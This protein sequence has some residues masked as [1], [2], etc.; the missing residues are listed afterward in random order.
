MTPE[1]VASRARLATETA[2]AASL[3]AAT[4]EASVASE[5]AE[6]RARRDVSSKCGEK[7][8]RV[9]FDAPRT[10]Q[11][12]MARA[13]L[14]RE[15]AASE[16]KARETQRMRAAGLRPLSSSVDGCERFSD[17][18]LGVDPTAHKAW[19]S[20]E[21]RWSRFEKDNEA[22]D[23]DGVCVYMLT[24][25]DIPFPSSGGALLKALAAWGE[26]SEQLFDDG[27]S[28]ARARRVAAMRWHPDK[29]TQR[30]GKRLDGMSNA[31]RES[32]ERQ[33]VETYQDIQRT[34]NDL[35]K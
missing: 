19:R 5:R 12:A 25:N 11:E 24:I 26:E 3:E 21:S 22:M 16:R 6:L 27:A 1:E 33:V 35:S 29:F 18:R 31:D 30:F 20:H 9:P 4:L 10:P 32:V 15:A 2:T 13:R 7:K 23:N 34:W 8:T 14:E 28:L 17:V